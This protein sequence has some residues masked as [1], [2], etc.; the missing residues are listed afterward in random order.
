[1]YELRNFQPL[2]LDDSFNAAFDLVGILENAPSHAL[3]AH[4]NSKNLRNR[5]TD[6]LGQ[7]LSIESVSQ[8]AALLE[9]DLNK[10]F[11]KYARDISSGVLEPSTIDPELNIF[12][13]RPDNGQLLLQASNAFDMTGYLTGLA[14]QSFDYLVL[15][16]S[17]RWHKELLQNGGWGAMV[18]PGRSIRPYAKNHRVAILRQRMINMGE[19][20]P[21]SVPADSEGGLQF[22][23]DELQNAVKSIQARHGLRADGIAGKLT[24][25]AVNTSVLARIEQIAVNLERMRW[26]NFDFGDRHIVVNQADYTMKVV[27]YNTVT[28]NSRV[29]VGKRKEHRTPEFSDVM[30]HMVV[31]PTWHIPFSIA[32]KEILPK[33]QEDPGYLEKHNMRLVSN[34]QPTD[35]WLVDWFSYNEKNFPYAVKQNPGEGNALGRIKFM[36]PNS[37]NIYLHDTQTRGLFNKDVRAYSHGC[38]RVHQP[39]ELAHTLLSQQE[40]DP[41]SKIQNILDTKKERTVRLQSP[42]DVHLTYRTAWIDDHGLTQFRDDIYG[43]DRKVADALINNGVS[44]R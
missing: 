34:K 20:H 12:P 9:I 6:L 41:V 21:S 7:D 24:I 4:Y 27:E 18:P 1:M 35:P 33:L 19:L 37:F 40:V 11:L 22:Y 29:I 25:Q 32:G 5:I 15:K 3:P 28:Y 43:R 23:D 8:T 10:A 16:E 42:V 44:I 30:T 36:F 31:N 39:I 17:L 2:W 38:V 13:H 14:P 26:M